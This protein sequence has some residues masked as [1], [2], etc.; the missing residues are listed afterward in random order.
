V[1]HAGD[2]V[3]VLRERGGVSVAEIVREDEIVPAF[4]KGAFCDVQEA[5][6]V[7]PAAA[8]EA[9]GD[10][11]GDGDRARRIWRESP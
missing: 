11:C 7:G 10:V 6:F 5:G 4:F 2:F 3:E 9:F 1:E 8:T